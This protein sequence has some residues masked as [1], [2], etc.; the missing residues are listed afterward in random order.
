M[1]NLKQ[2]QWLR[3]CG[4]LAIAVLIAPLWAVAQPQSREPRWDRDA[5]QSRSA[6]QIIN[7]WRDDVNLSMWTDQRQRIGEWSIRPGEQVVLQEGGQRVRV[8]PNYKIKV[9]DDWGW[10]DVAQVGQFRNGTWYVNVRDVWQA[11]HAGRQ[12]DSDNRYDN[13]RN[14]DNRRDEVSPRRDESPVGQIL[15]DF[16]VIK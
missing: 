6:I 5:D 2:T 3:W 7:D 1:Q 15:R 8:R 10:V 16:N 4:M 9:G 11:T 14:Y 13:Q 12:R